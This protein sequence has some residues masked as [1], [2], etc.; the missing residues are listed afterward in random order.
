MRDDQSGDNP[1]YMGLPHAHQPGGVA[2]DNSRPTRAAEEIVQ[3]GIAIGSTITG[4]LVF[5]FGNQQRRDPVEV[6]QRMVACR[7]GAPGG[8][9]DSSVVE[10][11]YFRRNAQ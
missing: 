1:A 9:L 10:L 3:N 5:T 8:A 7:S 6:E 2:V 11:A 4:T